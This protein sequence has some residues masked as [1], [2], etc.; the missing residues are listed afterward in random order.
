M[1]YESMRLAEDG[2]T[3]EEMVQ[4]RKYGLTKGAVITAVD[5][6][7]FGVSK[8]LLNTTSRA[9][10]A[11]VRKVLKDEGVDISN[12]SAMMAHSKNP[13]L[14]AK[15]RNAAE[16]AVS[17]SSVATAGDGLLHSGSW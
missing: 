12:P 6:G 9:V 2:L 7:T 16:T 14:K 13:I 10:P 8:W 1:G 5:T 17:V 15:A 3:P 4:A 11:A